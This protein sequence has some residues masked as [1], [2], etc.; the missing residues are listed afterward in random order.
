MLRLRLDDV[1]ETI[2]SGG[3]RFRTATGE[4]YLPKP[5]TEE[6]I[7]R[8]ALNLMT[9]EDI[10]NLIRRDIPTAQSKGTWKGLEQANKAASLH[11]GEHGLD[12]LRYQ[13]NTLMGKK[14]A[15]TWDADVTRNYVIWSQ[16][17][18]DQMERLGTY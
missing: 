13:A 18:L 16:K 5:L 15:G 2:H 17:L 8:D 1:L 4:K 10:Y 7:R 12:G 9:G 11:L 6:M 3:T 14:A